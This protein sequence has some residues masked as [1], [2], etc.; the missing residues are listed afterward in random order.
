[1]FLH[2]WGGCIDSF[3]AL[4]DR[5]SSEFSVTLV[6]LYGFGATP[7][8]DDPLTLDDYAEGVLRLLGERGI[9]D[10]ILI[11]HSFGG[12]VAMRIA[13]HSSVAR[14]LVLVDSAG[15]P[16]HRTL[17]YYIKVFA[18][19]LARKF[20]RAPRQA[21]SADYRA[22]SGPM[23]RT[24]VNVVNDDNLTDARRISRPTLL[25]WGEKDRDTPLYMCRKLHSLL[26]NS[27]TVVIEGAGHFSYLECPEYAYR[28]VRAFCREV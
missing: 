11:G 25:L 23:R 16:P 13:A 14:G 10:C 6:D 28:V 27:E 18:Y 9:E 21:G 3:R 26:R 7:H 8:P 17:K 20:G 19:K 22:L 4:A 1:M 2:G 5:L 24:F 15:I 12:R